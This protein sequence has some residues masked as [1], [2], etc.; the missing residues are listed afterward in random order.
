MKIDRA[1]MPLNETDR[2]LALKQYDILVEHSIDGTF[3]R[4]TALAARLFNVPVSIIGIVDVDHIRLVSK[5]GLE[6]TE[7]RFA[8]GLPAAAM[9]WESPCI[10]ENTSV[11]TGLLTKTLAAEVTGM[12]FYAGAP[13]IT[14]Q[15][16]NLGGLWIIDREPRVLNERDIANLQDLAYLVMRRVES[17]LTSSRTLAQIIRNKAANKK[18]S[19]EQSEIISSMS[20]EL[21]APLNAILGF[22]Q[23]MQM[24]NP[25]PT[26]SQKTSIE[27]IL[28]SGWYLLSLINQLL[29]SAAIES[30]EL[31]LSQTP[32]LLVNI[33]KEC[34]TMIKSLAQKKNVRLHISRY[35][36]PSHVLADETKL[37]QVLINL[38]TNAIKYNREGGNVTV[39]YSQNESGM[40][41]ISIRD[42]G[43]GLTQEQ[44]S[45]LFNPFNRLGREAGS[46]EGT[47]IGLVVTKKL[48]EFMGGEIGVESSVA[49]GST[50][51]IDVPSAEP[52][53]FKVNE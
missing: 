38:L 48:I 46:E 9:L 4:I 36:L 23:L 10:V 18:T 19:L 40:T 6:T 34:E 30:G 26:P 27:H 21:R 32:L 39:E 11:D 22:A 24:G 29:H 1:Q 25:P 8:P 13:L 16:F 2:L 42:T 5:Y 50:F 41:R 43:P 15:G 47:G 31:S 14:T 3:N 12:G 7:I 17:S 51:W 49:V 53:Q 37:K 35:G 45:K 28:E 44:I 20:H 33:L 52:P